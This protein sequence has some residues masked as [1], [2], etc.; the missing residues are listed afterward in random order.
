MTLEIE[1]P[2][3]LDGE[4]LDRCVAMVADL[5]RAVAATLLEDGAVRLDGI[6]VH[7]PSSRVSAGQRLAIEV[8]DPLAALPQPDP[9]VEFTVIY[10]DDDV[11]VIDKPDGLVVHP[12]SGNERGTLVNGLLARFPEIAAVG[13]PERPGLV[14]RLDKGTT[15]LLMV[16]R[17]ERAHESL[18]DQLVDH[19]ARRE[20]VALVWAVPSNQSGVVD[21]AIGRSPRDPTR[22]AV[23]SDGRPART[24]YEVLTPFTHPEPAALVRCRL[25]TGRTH[26]IRVHMTAIG[27]PVIGD[28]LYRGLRK[29]LPVTR[30]LLHAERLTF[31]HPDGRGPVSFFSPWP[32]DFEA[33]RL[34]LTEQ[35]R[36]AEVAALAPPEA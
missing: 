33:T 29:S 4:R 35:T 11:I 21:A 26:Q 36:A 13:D 3:G 7:K 31:E 10:A 18:I 20:Y 8:P 14:H 19:T 12:G 15:G 5:S 32:E 1:V 16:A 30:P 23:V 34:L 9:T 27:H 2:I 24:H 22:M 6:V 28:P 17:S 25:E